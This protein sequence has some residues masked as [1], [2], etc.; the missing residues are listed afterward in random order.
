MQSPDESPPHDGAPI[1]M[2]QLPNG[3]TI[4]DVSVDW[5]AGPARGVGRPVVHIDGHYPDPTALVTQLT[6]PVDGEYWLAYLDSG[7]VEAFVDVGEQSLDPNAVRYTDETGEHW[8]RRASPTL[9]DEWDDFATMLV[10]AV[11][12]QTARPAVL[13]VSDARLIIDRHYNQTAS[14]ADDSM[15]AP[16]VLI[17]DDS[18]ER[19]R[20][21]V[22]ELAGPGP[23]HELA[24]VTRTEMPTQREWTAIEDY[25]DDLQGS[26]E[27]GADSAGT[28]ADSADTTTDVETGAKTES[29]ITS[30]LE[31][32]GLTIKSPDPD[33]IDDALADASARISEIA[34]DL[35]DTIPDNDTPP[36]P[37]DDAT[38]GD[39]ASTEADP[40]SVSTDPD[41]A[42]RDERAED[43][44]STDQV[45]TGSSLRRRDSGRHHRRRRQ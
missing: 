43:P 20:W 8:L 6:P 36:T 17:E 34:A 27:T 40:D 39:D 18:T 41:Q 31:S 2:D 15:S 12:D 11:D 38:S 35:S 25:V 24:S 13:S 14:L 33:D 28:E 5:R 10:R 32:A 42:R 16:I 7:F 23:T 9:H 44:D 29:T 37:D 21:G 1:N 26:G 4:T 30:P 19:T 3:A 45:T 22:T